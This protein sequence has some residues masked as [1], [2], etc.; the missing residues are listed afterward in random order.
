MK[1]EDYHGK[2]YYRPE[3]E[4]LLKAK[5]FGKDH[6][7]EDWPWGRKQRCSMHFSIEKNKR[8]ERFVKQS[9][10]KGRTYKPKRSTYA[11]EMVIVEVNGK[12]GYV[13]STMY[14]SVGI[15]IEDGKYLS[16]TFFDEDADTLRKHF[17]GR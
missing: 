6:V 11:L 10:F 14:G 17:F 15:D 4:D 3:V 16:A 12:I 9:T 13:S 8:G 5:I 1:T 7:V 2:E